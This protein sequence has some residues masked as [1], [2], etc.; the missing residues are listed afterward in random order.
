MNN[1][2]RGRIH[3]SVDIESTAGPTLLAELGN[4]YQQERVLVYDINRHQC[5]RLSDLPG[6]PLQVLINKGR[7]FLQRTPLRSLFKDP[8]PAIHPNKRNMTWFDIDDLPPDTAAVHGH[9]YPELFASEFE[10]PFISIVLREPLERAVAQYL[11]WKKSKGNVRWR[12]DIPYQQGMKFEEFAFRDELKNFQFECM[13]DK[14][15]GDFDL[16][17]V[18][19]CLEGFIQQLRGEEPKKNSGQT[20]PGNIPPATYKKLGITEELKEEFS[21][22]N[23]KDYDLYRLAKEFMGF[24][25]E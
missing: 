7:Q 24:C 20:H 14:R 3:L 12:L 19:E 23:Q 9:Y 8:H 2:N 4:L 18:T 11:T 16:I 21:A 25:D 15:L 1:I 6:S 22:F 13:G 10:N 17:G 5:F